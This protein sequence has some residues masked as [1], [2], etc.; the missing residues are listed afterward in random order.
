[1]KVV[2]NADYTR[3]YLDPAKRSIGNAMQVF[4]RDG[5]ASERVA[6]EYP[7]GHR[8]RRKEG[9]PLLLAK[10]ERALR[11]RIPTRAAES[12]LSLFADRARL[13]AI[14]VRDFTGLFVA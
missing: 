12:I 4:F 6:V 8:R 10:F 11:D 2:E 7:V 9:V 14:P 5:T 1:M 13:E 3:D